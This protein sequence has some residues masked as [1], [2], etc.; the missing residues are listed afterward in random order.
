MLKSHFDA[1]EQYL[2]AR[3][4][5]AANT[6]HSLHKGT[7]RES[8][9][10]EFLED[11]LG[12]KVA[13]GTGE[14]IAADSKPNEPRNQNDIVIYKRDYP[15]LEFGG[16][17]TGFLVESVIATIE[18]KS[19]LSDQDIKQ[20]VNTA[21]NIK[22]LRKNVSEIVLPGHPAPTILNYVVAYDGPAQMRTVHNWITKAYAS[23]GILYP[24]WGNTIQGRMQ[25]ASPSL[26]A[27]FVLEKGFVCF[28]NSSV[29][30]TADVV[31]GNYPEK[32]WLI[33]DMTEGNLFLLFLLLTQA[34][35]DIS[36]SRLN[37]GPYLAT[38]AIEDIHLHFEE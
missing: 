23:E 24:P 7:P 4:R 6:G 1:I 17:I 13:I 3:S 5:I 19:T 22:N 34:I 9:V 16:G 12:Q 33:A 11:H 28:D 15:K 27:V 2:T 29:T 30:F 21:R 10:R 36:L 35:S 32:K 31:R 20:S 8:F 37:I 18:V 26:D 25:V 14:I 38:F